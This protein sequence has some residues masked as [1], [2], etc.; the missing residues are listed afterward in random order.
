MCAYSGMRIS[1]CVSLIAGPFEEEPA[2][3]LL[4]ILAFSFAFP[5][6]IFTPINCSNESPTLASGNGDKFFLAL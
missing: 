3:L 4:A 1:V 5:F 2:W 6:A